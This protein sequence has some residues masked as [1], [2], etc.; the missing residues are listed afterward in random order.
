MVYDWGQGG[1]M[2]QITTLIDNTSKRGSDLLAEHGFSCLIERNGE[3]ILFDTGASRAFIE[4]AHRLGR[5]LSRLDHLVL[6]HRHWDHGGGVIPLLEEYTYP[7]LRLWSGQG[8]E[9]EKFSLEGESL[10]PNGVTFNREIIN[11][12]KVMWHTVCSNTV[13]ISRGVWLITAFERRNPIEENN[14]RFRLKDGSIDPFDD[15]VALIVNSS[16]GLVLI[17][18]CSHPGI[19]NIIDAT[20]ERFG[21]PIYALL[22]GIHLSDTN[23]ERRNTVLECLLTYP[24]EKIGVCHCT[25]GEAIEMIKKRAEGS[26]DNCSGATLTIV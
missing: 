9:D 22:G 8:Y 21:R 12:H 4:N 15:E 20:L 5:D 17:V 10:R 13:M 6:S 14:P 2:L 16:Q 1:I 18:G 11:R 24:I 19:L 25:G 23:Q 7:S 3:K 26:F